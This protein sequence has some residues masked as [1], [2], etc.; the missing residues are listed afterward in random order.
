M[1]RQALQNGA[2]RAPD[3]FPVAAL[4]AFTDTAQGVLWDN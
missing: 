3:A 4:D 2:S 1:L